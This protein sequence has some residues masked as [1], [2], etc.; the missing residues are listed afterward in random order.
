MPYLNV[1][2][3]YRFNDPVIIEGT[4]KG[5]QVLASA[6]NAVLTSDTDNPC[7]SKAVV[8]PDGRNYK[9]VVVQKDDMGNIPNQG[10]D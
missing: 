1:I 5:L 10:G 6:L 9:I 4:Q 7:S 8:A 3:P 2:V